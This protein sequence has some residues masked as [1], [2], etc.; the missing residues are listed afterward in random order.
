MLNFGGIVVEVVVADITKEVTDFV[1]DI[2]MDYN[3]EVTA[4]D[5]MNIIAEVYCLRR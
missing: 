2:I 5:V 4:R 3:G 1:E